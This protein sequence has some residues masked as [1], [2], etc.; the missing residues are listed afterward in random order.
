MSK[1]DT[2]SKDIIH[3]PIVEVQYCS[4]REPF[5]THKKAEDTHYFLLLAKHRI[6]KQKTFLKNVESL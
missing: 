2:T 3:Q 6:T 5:I 1:L 4:D